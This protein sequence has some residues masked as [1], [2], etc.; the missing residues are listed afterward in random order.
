MKRFIVSLSVAAGRNLACGGAALHPPVVASAARRTEAVLRDSEFPARRAIRSRRSLEMG[1]RRRGRHDAGIARRRQAA[2]RPTSRS[3]RPRRNA[4]G[5][6]T[7]AVVISSYYSGDSTDMYEQWVKGTALSG[8]VPII[9]P[10]RPID[11]DRYYVVMVDPLGTW[12]AS[13]PSDG[14]G[15]KI[16]AIQLLRHGAGQLPHAARPPEGRAN[17]AL[18]AGVSMGG[19]QTYVWGVMHPEYVQRPDADRRHHAVRRRGSGRQLDLPAD[20]G[21]DRDRT[22]YGKRP[23]AITTICR[24]R[25]IRCPASPSAGRCSGSPA[26]IFAYRTTQA[27]TAVQPGSVLLGSAERE[28]RHRAS[29]SAP[30]CTTPSISSGATG[31]AKPTT[32]I[33]ISAASSRGR[34]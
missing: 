10:G 7:N 23:R 22:R 8:G 12:G 14:L 5:E 34:W 30:R 16:P 25:S 20:D 31:S 24:K 15:I 1:K 18:A 26:T 6:I 4:A 9:G 29:P 3:A 17:V 11:T 28:G 21:R 2:H 19:T 32:S 27:F 33:R 13:K